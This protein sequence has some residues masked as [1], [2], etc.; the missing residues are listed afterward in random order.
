MTPSHARDA[1]RDND[2]AGATTAGDVLI[3]WA[4]RTPYRIALT[5]MRAPGSPPRSWTCEALR[6]DA[7]T[8]A[9]A[10]LSRFAPG[11]RIAVWAPHCPEAVL[12]QFAAALAGLPLVAV[13]P[14]CGAGELTQILNHCGAVGLFTMTVEGGPAPPRG[15]AS[16]AAALREVVDLSDRRTLFAK[17]RCVDGLPEVRPLDPA[18]IRYPA[19]ESG[20]PDGEAVLQRDLAD[21]LRRVIAGGARRGDTLLP[22]FPRSRSPERPAAVAVEPARAG[23]V[24]TAA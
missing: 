3:E 5:E 19:G 6:D 14:A 24:V 22:C 16:A 21:A 2:A 13:E 10:L 20:S 9:V 11:E 12:L 1:T 4:R 17:R 18:Q 7:A 8:L 23:R 15:V